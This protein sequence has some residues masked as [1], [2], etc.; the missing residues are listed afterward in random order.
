MATGNVTNTALRLEAV[1]R[2]QPSAA[3]RLA[4]DCMRQEQFSEET[5]RAQAKRSLKMGGAT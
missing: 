2:A 3:K 1:S 5:H 4:Q